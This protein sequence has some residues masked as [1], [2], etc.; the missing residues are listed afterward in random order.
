[1]EKSLNPAA[2]R[3]RMLAALAGLVVLGVLAWFTIDPSAVF[4]VH[5]F[6]NRYMGFEGRDVPVR[7][8]P[9]LFFG[10]FGLRIV[11]ANLRARFEESKE[12]QR[13]M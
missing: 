6:D 5:G 8:L 13:L 11:S 2:S 9:I 12:A 4:H 1:M 7:W 3:E 10:L